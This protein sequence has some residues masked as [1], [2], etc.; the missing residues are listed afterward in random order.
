MATFLPELTPEGTDILVT[1]QYPSA[2]F[3]T[4]LAAMLTAMHVDTLLITGYSTS[5]CV[6][7]SVLDALQ[8]G[9]VPFVVEDA[10]A[11][12]AEGPHTSNIFDL[13]SKYAEIVSTEEAL[14]LMAG[15]SE[16]PPPLAFPYPQE[17]AAL[18]V[19]AGS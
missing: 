17:T 4:S 5:G 7:A 13:K 3:G 2:F 1:K 9:F 10:C 14:S 12:R 8:N 6:R 18:A 15:G 11:D 19:N 16:F